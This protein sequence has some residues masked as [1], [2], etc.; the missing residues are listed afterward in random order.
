[1]VAMFMT[2]ASYM[3][4][5]SGYTMLEYAQYQ[6]SPIMHMAGKAILT[7]FPNLEALN[8]KNYIATDAPL[9]IAKWI[10]GYGVNALYILVILTL[11]AMIF[12]RRSFDNA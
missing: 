12:S 7:F 5:H 10:T 9:E 2:I 1:M 6:S 11:S 8:L 4:G 3:I